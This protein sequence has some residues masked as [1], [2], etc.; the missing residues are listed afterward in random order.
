[1][2]GLLFPALLAECSTSYII[3]DFSNSFTGP[4]DSGISTSDTSNPIDA[5]NA[6]AAN[7]PTNV[8]QTFDQIFGTTDLSITV[9]ANPNLIPGV[10]DPPIYDSR[11]ALANP[12]DGDNLFLGPS[13]DDLSPSTSPSSYQ[14][15]GGDEAIDLAIMGVEGLTLLAA[16][17][18]YWTQQL[19]SLV[20]SQLEAPAQAPAPPPARAHAPPPAL[21]HGQ[22]A[23]RAGGVVVNDIARV[24][25]NTKKKGFCPVMPY[26]YH[27]LPFCD[28]GTVLWS[29]TFRFFVLIGVTPCT[30]FTFIS[31]EALNLNLDLD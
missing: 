15:A 29:P 5:F 23:N 2:R 31:F 26:T 3:P 28:T 12:I 19:G 13:G 30:F 20:Q 11:L 8:D 21:A 17:V 4:A 9:A 7:P 6:V 18:T 1:M 27:N 16:S 25:V 22:A 14:V 10:T 24:T